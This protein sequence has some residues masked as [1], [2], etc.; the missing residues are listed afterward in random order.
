MHRSM[1]RLR[2]NRRALPLFTVAFLGVW[3]GFQIATGAPPSAPLPPEPVEVN[4]PTDA[5]DHIRVA[6]T[7]I[8][9]A[10]EWTGKR[11]TGVVIDIWNEIAGRIGV[12]TDFVLEPTFV[13]L[14]EVLPAG[15]ADVS[16][17]PLAIT[18]EREQMLDFTHAIFNSGMRIAVRNR[19]DSGFLTAVKSFLS[20]QLLELLGCVMALAFF[21]GHVLW[22]CERRENPNSFPRHYLRGVGE[23]MWWIGCTI[24]TGGCDNKHVGSSLGRTIAFGWMV[25]GIVLLASFTSVLTATMTAERVVG[26]IHGPRDLAGRTVGCQQAALSAK[27][28]RQRGALVEEFPT[29]KEALDALALGMVEAVVGENQSLMVLVNQPNR[30]GMRLVGPIFETFDY[31]F[32]VPTGSPL[33]KR[34][35]RAIL[36]IRE[37]GTL[38]RIKSE[39]LGQHD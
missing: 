5:V 3:V 22:W 16:L 24:V 39:W 36:Q 7:P 10:V 11:P 27:T 25:G 2:H 17:G 31:G 34:L 33:R 18:A 28:A 30:V 6:V 29:V 21:T 4:E 15:Q 9:S 12:A 38:D 32:G 23:A 26:T 14:L 8:A 19:D 20:W 37:D 13:R 35:N 1:A